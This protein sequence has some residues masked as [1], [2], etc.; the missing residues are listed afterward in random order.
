MPSETYTK[1]TSICPSF[2]WPPGVI[3]ISAKSCPAKTRTDAVRKMKNAPQKRYMATLMPT[4]TGWVGLKSENVKVSL[5]LVR[6]KWACK[7]QTHVSAA[8]FA[9]P[10]KALVRREREPK[11][12]RSDRSEKRSSK[13]GLSDPF[14]R[15][16][17]EF[18][19]SKCFV[20][21]L[22]IMLPAAAGSTFL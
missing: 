20:S 5:A 10:K 9:C 18:F 2:G 19:A 11:R 21:I 17:S 12:Q 6:P 7:Q 14:R 8:Y 1:Y 13:E 4:C 22:R 3:C 16:K 15:R